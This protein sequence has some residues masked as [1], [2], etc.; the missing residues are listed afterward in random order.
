MLTRSR[1][2]DIALSVLR[3]GDEKEGVE[4]FKVFG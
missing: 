4:A 2:L 3:E 1:R